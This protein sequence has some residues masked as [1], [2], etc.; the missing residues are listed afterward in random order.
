M[1][2]WSQ[3]IFVDQMLVLMGSCDL[4]SFPELKSPPGFPCLNPLIPYPVGIW[5]GTVSIRWELPIRGS[6][7]SSNGNIFHVTG[8]LWGEC[9]DHRWIPLTKASDAEL[10]CTVAPRENNCHQEIWFW[11]KFHNGHQ[12]YPDRYT[13]RCILQDIMYEKSALIQIMALYHMTQ[14]K[15]LH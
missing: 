6:A 4:V 10:S 8:P 7:L 15:P 12:E 13:L 2:E 9:T 11:N 3:K 5:C 14:Y 1:S